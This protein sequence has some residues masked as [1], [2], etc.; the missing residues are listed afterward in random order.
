MPILSS[1]NNT[2]RILNLIHGAKKYDDAFFLCNCCGKETELLAASMGG[3]L[4]RSTQPTLPCSV[5]YEPN[6]RLEYRSK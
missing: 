3:K 5:C 2:N 1:M 6:S 4:I